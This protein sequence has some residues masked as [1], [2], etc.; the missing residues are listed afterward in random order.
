MGSVNYHTRTRKGNAE[1][2]P[3]KHDASRRMRFNVRVVSPTS[4]SAHP[5]TPTHRDAGARCRHRH[6]RCRRPPFDPTPP[7]PAP[8]NVVAALLAVG[9]G[10]GC[11]SGRR[12]LPGLHDLPPIPGHFGGGVPQ[13]PLRRP[14]RRGRFACVPRVEGVRWAWLDRFVW[15]FEHTQH[16]SAPVTDCRT[17][18][19]SSPRT[20]RWSSST[21]A[22]AHFS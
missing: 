14:H 10:Y 1:Q 3:R 22:Y 13:R 21:G 19:S 12:L 18:R 11:C 9:V 5:P 6:C 20:S 15:L 4:N 7:A 2:S 17:R 8:A 16:R